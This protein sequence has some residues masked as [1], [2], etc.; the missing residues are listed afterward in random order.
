MSSY[1]FFCSG[2]MNYCIASF[3]GV[4]VLRSKLRY[5]SWWKTSRV[6]WGGVD[7]TLFLLLLPK[8]LLPQPKG[9]LE[10][11]SWP[12]IW[13]LIWVMFIHTQAQQPTLPSHLSLFC[14]LA[15]PIWPPDERVLLLVGG[16]RQGG[17]HGCWDGQQSKDDMTCSPFETMV[18][19]ADRG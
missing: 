6:E 16:S 5:W 1:I 9:K 11:P 10:F 4:S 3:S 14:L 12:E 8:F 7:Y 15:R 13:P 18:G 17:R 2:K 19:N